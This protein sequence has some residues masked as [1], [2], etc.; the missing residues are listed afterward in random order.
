MPLLAV[1]SGINTTTPTVLSISLTPTSISASGGSLP[2]S[3]ASVTALASGGS[4]SYSYSWTRLS[5]YL[6]IVAD[7]PSSASTT[8]TVSIQAPGLQT[9]VYQCVATDTVNPAVTGS[10]NI[11]VSMTKV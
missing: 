10:I 5:G 2:Y 11:L 3:T 7:S 1:L 6:D 4:G 9:A 8:F